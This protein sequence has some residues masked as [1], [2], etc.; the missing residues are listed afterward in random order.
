M[1]FPKSMLTKEEVSPIASQW[2]VGTQFKNLKNSQVTTIKK[3]D[4]LGNVIITTDAMP[5]KEWT[6]PAE[7][8]SNMIKKGELEL[9]KVQKEGYYEDIAG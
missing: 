1:A 3:F 6:W 4:Q 7:E 2:K 8:L 5:G 9:I